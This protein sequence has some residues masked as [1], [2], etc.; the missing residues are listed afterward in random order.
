MYILGISCFYHDSAACL[1]QDG[2]HVYKETKQKNLC[3]AGGVAINCVANGR[4][5]RESPKDLKV[6]NR[7]NKISMSTYLGRFI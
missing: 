3:L 1:I 5:P 2:K 7:K 4:I 6:G